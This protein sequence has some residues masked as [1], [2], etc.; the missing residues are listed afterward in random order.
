MTIERKTFLNFI[1]APNHH[2]YL[3]IFII[4]GFEQCDEET[5]YVDSDICYG[6]GNE[7]KWAVKTLV[8]S[9]LFN[10]WMLFVILDGDADT[11]ND[12]WVSAEELLYY[13]ELPVALR[14]TFIS[15]FCFSKDCYT[16]S[17]DIQWMAE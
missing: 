10:S 14:S 5:V 1:V 16:T 15:F 12:N 3:L 8:V 2:I 4:S 11:D 6:D 13:M 17:L 7:N 9:L